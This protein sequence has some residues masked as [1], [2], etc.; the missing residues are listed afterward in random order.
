M[1]TNDYS[2]IQ[3]AL[4]NFYLRS[5]QAA[6][7]LCA[8]YG[9]S[10]ARAK[11]LIYIGRQGTTRS[12]DMVQSSGLAPRTVTEAIDALEA[13]GL[14]DRTPDPVDRR[15]KRIMLTPAGTAALEA[16]GPARQQLCERLFEALDADERAQ[17]TTLLERLNTRLAELEREDAA[18]GP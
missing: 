18:P 16:L 4:R 2:A 5:Q 15:V 9:I 12:I 14:V 1:P 7:R 17:L 11:L 8:P 10:L 6:E 13:E 3:E